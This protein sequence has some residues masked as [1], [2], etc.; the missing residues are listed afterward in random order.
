MC[1]FRLERYLSETQQTLNNLLSIQV[2]LNQARISD[3]IRDIQSM[4]G[5]RQGNSKQT[6]PQRNQSQNNSDQGDGLFTRTNL[7]N[8]I[9][10][11]TGS[12]WHD[13]YNFP[14]PQTASATGGGWN[15]LNA[16][17]NDQTSFRNH[18]TLED[19]EVGQRLIRSNA[20]EMNSPAATSESFELVCVVNAK[21]LTITFTLTSL[22]GRNL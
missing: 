15:S 12:Y 6:Q 13:G 7:N 20:C 1:C 8:L 10:Q 19:L 2:H 21:L 14:Q 16:A 17:Y 18:L 11:A 5:S 4:S 3:V 22:I 9:N